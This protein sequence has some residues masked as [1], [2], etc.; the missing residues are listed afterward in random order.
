MIIY[1]KKER[2]KNRAL[3]NNILK[4]FSINSKMQN[5]LLVK[6]SFSFSFFN[7]FKRKYRLSLP[8]ILF[9]NNV[10]NRFIS[11]NLSAFNWKHFLLMDLL[12]FNNFWFVP[13]KNSLVG[14]YNIYWRKSKKLNLLEWR[15]KKVQ[16]ANYKSCIISIHYVD[17]S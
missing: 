2:F 4:S 17:P 6:N 15:P 1:I 16:I 10:K 11:N 5:L 8:D 13:V 3:C 12:R 9:I 7:I 14:I